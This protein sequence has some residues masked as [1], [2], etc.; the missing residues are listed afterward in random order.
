[1]N[2]IQNIDRLFKKVKKFK[3]T[4]PE[5]A[6]MLAR[7]TAEAIAKHI[8][9]A[10]S[11]SPGGLMLDKLIEKMSSD[12]MVAKKILNPLRTIQAYGNYGAH[13]QQNDYGEIDKEYA[14]PCIMA[15]ETVYKWFD[16]KYGVPKNIL[17]MSVNEIELSVK[18]ANALNN[19][20][21]L[22]VGAV[23][24]KSKADLMKIFNNATAF[25]E[26]ESALSKLGVKLE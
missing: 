22:T 10:S 4:D 18:A 2:S 11:F 7:K 21:I 9:Q 24:A 1:M 26:I 12:N 23:W 20:N 5:V 8:I 3:N 16:E 19:A 15:I 14:S 13:D 17:N 25:A 6:L